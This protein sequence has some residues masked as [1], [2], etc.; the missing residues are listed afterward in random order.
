ML[1]LECTARD[2]TGET[3]RTLGELIPKLELPKPLDQAIHKLWG[4][5]SQHGRH[6]QEGGTAGDDDAEL[7]VSIACAVSIF[8]AKRAAFRPV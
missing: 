3:D 4:F 2:V 7:I 6:L 8:L 1:W 5:A